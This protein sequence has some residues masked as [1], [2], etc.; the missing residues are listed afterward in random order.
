MVSWTLLFLTVA[1]TPAP[2]R[3]RGTAARAEA[4]GDDKLSILTLL[5]TSQDVAFGAQYGTNAK[6]LLFEPLVGYGE[7]GEIVPRLARRW[8]HSEDY[9]TWTYHL[10]TDVT[11][12]DGTPFTSRDVAFTVELFA[13]PPSFYYAVLE[14]VRTPDD[15]TVVIRTSRPRGQPDW[16]TV[17]YP[18]HLL[19][20]RN[21]EDMW[22]WDFWRRPVGNGPFRLRRYLPKTLWEFEANP[23]YYLGRPKLDRVRI[24]F[25]G[26]SP[27][28]ELRAGNVDGM[29][30]SR[31][32][33]MNLRSDPRFRVYHQVWG[34][35]LLQ[36]EVIWW[37]NEHPFLGDAHVRQA[38]TQAIDRR[39]LL[40]LQNLPDFLPV[41]DV[42]ITSRQLWS[43]EFPDPLTHDPSRARRLLDAAGWHEPGSG[44]IRERDGVEARFTALVGSDAAGSG[45]AAVYVQEALSEIGVAMEIQYL[46]DPP[47]RQLR[48]G[49]YEAAFD[50]FHVGWA[51]T[52]LEAMGYRESR[53]LGPLSLVETT[54]EPTRRDSLFRAL[55]PAFRRDLPIT[56]LG[57]RAVASVAHRRVRG[58]SSP[59]RADLYYVAGELWLDDGE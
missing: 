55:W 31:S 17:Y 15:S 38:L 29:Q 8:E 13:G 1:C 14:H 22:V 36:F 56:F 11:W 26:G 16:Y 25:G 46:P 58:L 45:Y 44:G 19:G 3:S 51:T 27:L 37:H 54:V 35:S 53:V 23:D 18:E 9:R 30:A 42:P 4:A 10:R 6:F 39:Q 20:D 2:D 57:T 48:A 49:D 32:L 41:V 7:E 28:V 59:H 52:E 24:K 47:R 21:P 34:E 33:L 12:H 43:G 50:R 5:D 40:S